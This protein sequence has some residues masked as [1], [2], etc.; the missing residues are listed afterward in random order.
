MELV[1][2]SEIYIDTMPGTCSQVNSLASIMY[3]Y[4]SEIVRDLMLMVRRCLDFEK[5][6]IHIL[7]WNFSVKNESVYE[8][9][10]KK[11]INYDQHY[12]IDREWVVI[13]GTRYHQYIYRNRPIIGMK[14][15][16][17]E[18]DNNNIISLVVGG[19][20]IAQDFYYAQND[21]IFKEIFNASTPWIFSH[22]YHAM[23]L[24]VPQGTRCVVEITRKIDTINPRI[25]NFVQIYKNITLQYYN[26]E[27]TTFDYLTKFINVRTN[28][29]IKFII[30]SN[31][32]LD[33]IWIELESL[34]YQVPFIEHRNNNLY[35]Y[36]INITPSAQ[37]RYISSDINIHIRS[38]AINSVIMLY[39]CIDAAF[40][41]SRGL[42][43][44]GNITRIHKFNNN[45]IAN[46]QFAN[47][48]DD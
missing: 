34:F 2:D 7:P 5:Y 13:D 47:L 43:V 18:Q 11:V 20:T 36:T 10:F 6:L 30:N 12:D 16:S 22:Q 38:S 24:C 37:L 26:V 15:I 41:F 21:I 28:G 4:D 31:H 27:K 33:R 23:Q 42:L 17:F 3:G 1:D 8:G 25:Q 19:M 9:K 29:V 35:T 14:V 44:V 48:V 45:D 32:K 46:F 40:V 39:K